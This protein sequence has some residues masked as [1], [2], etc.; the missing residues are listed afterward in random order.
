ME[1]ETRVGEFSGP[2]EKLL[3][4]IEAEKMDINEVSLAKVTD[5]FLRYLETFKGGLDISGTRAASTEGIAIASLPTLSPS[6][7]NLFFSSQ[8]IYCRA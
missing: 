3:E 2:L 5:D 1:Y 8:N 4:L 6:Q 7:A